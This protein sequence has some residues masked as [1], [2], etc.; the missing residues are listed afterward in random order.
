[1][2]KNNEPE[3]RTKIDDINDSLSSIEQKVQNNQKVIM[4]ACVAVAA[5]VCVV[6][7]YIYGIRKPGIESANN[8]IG[9][10]DLELAMGNDSV[11]L[12]QYMQVADEYGYEGGNRAHLNAAIILYQQGKYQEALN[13]LDD[14]KAS[15]SIIGAAS[16]SLEGDCYVNLEDYDKAV[17]CFAEAAKISDNNPHYTPVFL[18]KEATVQRELKN[19]KAEAELYNRIIEEYPDYAVDSRID[20]TKYLERARQ[21]AEAEK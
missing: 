20:F 1:M 10:A 13:Y 7:L 2:A 12:A 21:Q 18:M 11:A 4:W 16:K 14:Y 3:T 19:Y 15:E 5:V 17:K 8:A 6:L 9:Q